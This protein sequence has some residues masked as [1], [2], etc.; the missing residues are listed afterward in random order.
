MGALG[1]QRPPTQIDTNTVFE[2]D[3]DGRHT[4]SVAMPPPGM[5]SRGEATAVPGKSQDLGEGARLATEVPVARP[6][7]GD[8]MDVPNP[9]LV[10]V[11]PHRPTMGGYHNG[12]AAL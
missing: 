1:V 2:S 8:L 11:I 9:E 5:P 6:G 10:G 4:P 3:M 7:T 12:V